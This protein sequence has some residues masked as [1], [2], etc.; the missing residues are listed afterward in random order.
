[1][2]KLNIVV[3]AGGV[4]ER[5]DS[6]RKIT[7]SSS[8]KLGIKIANELARRYPDAVFTI[9]GSKQA[10][11]DNVLPSTVG[12]KWIQIE[13][14][15]DL[16]KEVRKILVTEQVDIFIHSMAVADYTTDKVVD[17]DKFSE[18]IS[19][20]CTNVEMA[21]EMSEVDT[22]SKMPSSLNMM[23]KMKK[24]PKIIRMIK[25]LSPRTFLVGFKLLNDVTEEKLFDVGFN[26]LRENRCNL[27]VA[28]DLA[29]IRKGNHRALVIYPE[30]SYDV[31]EGKDEIA[32]GL[33]ELIDKRAFV[34]HPKSH[35]IN[36]TNY[37]S[38]NSDINKIFVEIKNVG[39]RLYEDGYLPEVK[40]HERPDEIGTYGNISVALEYGQMLI[41]GRNVHKGRLEESDICLINKV[42]EETKEPSIYANVYYNGTVKPSIDTAIHAKIYEL[43]RCKAIMHVHT[44]KV[45]LGYPYIDEQFPCGSMEERDAVIKAMR[46]GYEYIA[47]IGHTHVIQMKKHGLIIAGA[48]LSACEEKLR[49]LFLNTPYINTD[50]ICTD[51]EVLNH[52]DEVKADFT[53]TS[54]VLY[55]LE[56]HDETIGCVWE[57]HDVTTIDFG[58][59]TKTN[60]RKGMHIVENYLSL[61]DKQYMLHTTS[62]CNIENFYKEKY[63][64]VDLYHDTDGLIILYK[65]IT[66]DKK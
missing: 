22:S 10:L 11:N 33:V 52:I 64:F 65:P 13:S 40:N 21:L 41:T 62:G 47:E 38:S 18:L 43:T 24:T 53:K 34:K 55:N 58:L 46:R 35:V 15:A 5:I 29:N 54:G 31:F 14:T 26:L 36:G 32:K 16:E 30:K 4:T 48:T 61:Y 8:G 44:N 23:I 57:N 6:V 51:K 59:F 3:T 63:G 37:V 39:K 17:F 9:I 60:C 66:Q 45:F 42:E 56:L 7:N 49:E 20:G 25:T 50:A 28:N 12:T 19:N 27:V 2:K 1:M